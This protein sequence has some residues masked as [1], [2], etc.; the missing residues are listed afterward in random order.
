MNVIGILNPKGGSGKTTLTMNLSKAL[1]LDGYA[2]LA[3][4]SDP[5]G[6]L[7]DWYGQQDED[8][9]GADVAALD[10]KSIAR[11][12]DR[13]GSGYDFVLIDG[14]AKIE[15]K[16]SVNVV[17]ACDMILIPVQ[18]TPADIWG[19]ADLIEIIQTRQ[20][21]TNGH[22]LAALVISRQIVGTNLAADIARVLEGYEMPIFQARTSQRVV[23]A[24][25]MVNG[26]SVLDTKPN[27][28]ATAEITA[29]K[30]EMLG[31]IN[32]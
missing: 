31:F 21:V 25:A 2:V 14:A 3:I 5:Q 28:K 29:I 8:N 30:N 10:A 16:D 26:E 13:I 7:R 15:G 17:K 20:S 32:G 9:E 22:P 18:P 12:L 23:Y 6:T 4:D 1:H 19:A 27:G 24:E 11:G